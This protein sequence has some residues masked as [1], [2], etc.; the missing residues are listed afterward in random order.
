[1][2]EEKEGARLGGWADFLPTWR[3]R[4]TRSIASRQWKLWVSPGHLGTGPPPEY[5]ALGTWMVVPSRRAAIT[6]VKACGTGG[7]GE[8]GGS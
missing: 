4:T 3:H 1:M 6:R 2:G 5:P 8:A 7:E